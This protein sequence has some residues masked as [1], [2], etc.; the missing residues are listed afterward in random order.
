MDHTFKFLPDYIKIAM[1]ELSHTQGIGNRISAEKLS[2]V[3]TE[4]GISGVPVRCS[5]TEVTCQILV[6]EN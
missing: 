3:W 4:L 2:P 5:Q 1:F 6:K